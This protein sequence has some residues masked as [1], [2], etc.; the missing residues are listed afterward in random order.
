MSTKFLST[1]DAR[2]N[3]KWWVIDAKDLP[4]GRLAT[5]AAI[6]IRGKHKATFTP[7]TECGDFV[8]VINAEKALLTGNKNQDKMYRHH[9]GFVG[10]LKE[11]RGARMIEKKP[12]AVIERAVG[13]MVPSGV[14]GHRV[15]NTLKVYRGAEHPHIAQAPEVFTIKDLRKKK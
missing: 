15:L 5:E 9:T 8:I 3:A 4:V 2:Q 7:A 14:L 12:E 10:G 11:I 13:G 1:E 6:L